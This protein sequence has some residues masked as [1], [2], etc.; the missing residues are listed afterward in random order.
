MENAEVRK[1]KYVDP[2]PLQPSARKGESGENSIAF[3]LYLLEFQVAQSKWLSW[4][5]SPCTGFPYHRPLSF[6]H[7]ILTDLLSTLC[8]LDYMTSYHSNEDQLLISHGGN[9]LALGVTPPSLQVAMIKIAM[10]Q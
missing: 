8:N 5:L 3:F 2:D 9:L 10:K 1:P 4:Q 6:T 7:H